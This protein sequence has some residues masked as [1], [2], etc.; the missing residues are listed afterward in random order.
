MKAR[1]LAPFDD[2]KEGVP[3]A[4]GDVFE[5][6]EERF[7]EINSTTFGTLVETVEEKAATRKTTA[8]KT[9]ARKAAASKAKEQ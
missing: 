6:T 7:E 9:T 1:A 8:R 5:V 3:R 4:K 2:L